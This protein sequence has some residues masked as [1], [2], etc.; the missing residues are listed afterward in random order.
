MITVTNYS[1]RASELLS[2]KL[3]DDG[4]VYQA[5]SVHLSRAKL[6]TRSTIDMPKQNFL[7]PEFREN[8]RG[9]YPYFGRYPN[10]LTT[11]WDRSKEAPKPKTSSIRLTLSREFRLVTDRQTDKHRA[12]AST[13]VSIASRG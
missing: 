5:L 4:P 11:Q 10:F 1:G 9:K 6:I 3:S 12:I 13:R 8:F 7:S 2:T